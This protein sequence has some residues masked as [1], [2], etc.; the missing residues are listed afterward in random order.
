MRVFWG[1]WGF[2]GEG[3]DFV[4]LLRIVEDFKD[5]LLEEVGELWVVKDKAQQRQKAHVQV[6]RRELPRRKGKEKGGWGGEN[7]WAIVSI[8]RG[9]GGLRAMHEFYLEP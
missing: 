8:S 4:G 3:G 7:M 2:L 6:R 9:V 1:F 5:V